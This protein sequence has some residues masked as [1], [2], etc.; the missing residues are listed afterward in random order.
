MVIYLSIGYH[1]LDSNIK[2]IGGVV[3]KFNLKKFLYVTGISV[4]ILVS[5]LG[6]TCSENITFASSHLFTVYQNGSPIGAYESREVAIREARKWA[7]S[8]VKQG[9]SF[10][11]NRSNDLYTV[12]QGSTIIGAYQSREVAIREARKWANSEV[13]QDGTTVWNRSFELFTV[14]QNGKPIGAYESREVA[15]R[16]AGRWANSQVQ[17]GSEVIW[18]YHYTSSGTVVGAE[19]GYYEDGVLAFRIETRNGIR[20]GYGKVY[21]EYGNL[22]GEGNFLNDELN[23]YGAVYYPN[24]N[25]AYLG[26]FRNSEPHGYGYV[27]DESGSSILFGY[28]Q[29][30]DLI[31]W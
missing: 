6:V 20:R 26:E 31:Y 14:Y 29:N 8:E 10:I 15:I 28:F 23:G 21:D 2:K 1:N 25:V 11:W 27:Y 5:S 12:Y 24:G 19:Y 30:G 17:F 9:G 7:N 18:E 16:Q 3:L 4:T 22:I 13:R